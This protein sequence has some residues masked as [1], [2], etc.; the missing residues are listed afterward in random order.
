MQYTLLGRTGMT[1]SRLCLGTMNFGA[2]TSEAESCVIMDRALE[3]GVNF[4]DTANAYGWKLGEGI[5]E[6]IIGRWFAGGGGRRE[7]TILATKVYVPMGMGPNDCGLSAY[8]IRMACEES[9]RRLQT[10][11]IDVY[12]MH[13][14]DRGEANA[15]DRQVWGL[16]QHDVVRPPH[17]Q[18][19]T[20]WEEIYQAFEVLVGQGKVIYAAC[21][22]FAGWHIARG[23]ERAAARNFLGPV[24]E[25]S[26]YNLTERTI[27]LEVIPACRA[28]GMSIVPWSPLAGGLLAGAPDDPG[29]GRR[30]KLGDKIEKV[31]PQL[32]AYEALCKEI[33]ESPADTALAWL[34][35]QEMV[36][37]PVIGPRTV[38]QF[39]TS[40]RAVEV[41]LDTEILGH[42]DEIFPGPGGEAPEAYAW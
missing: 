24:C 19:D 15:L 31:R 10:D 2:E 13:H 22:N 7:Q 14:V 1:V 16:P 30:S 29:S 21:S 17:L 20:S 37:G 12:Y 3:A 39:E 32:E 6:N 40:L 18:R 38:D 23:S 27:E 41:K 35:H 36:A 5:T 25:Q 42:L 8:H 28:Y 4:F 33:G 11:H 9:L 34:L 26:L